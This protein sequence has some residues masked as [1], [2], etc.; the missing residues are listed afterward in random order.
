MSVISS[1]RYFTFFGGGGGVKYI[2]PSLLVV[3][4][5]AA[6]VPLPIPPDSWQKEK[7][8]K[9]YWKQICRHAN[10]W[11]TNCEYAGGFNCIYVVLSLYLK[12]CI[13]V[14]RVQSR[15]KRLVNWSRI[16]LKLEMKTTRRVSQLSFP[17][18]KST[19]SKA[20]AAAAAATG[21]E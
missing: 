17:S 15:F 6:G 2:H 10:S 5:R 1:Y 14:N 16:I 8:N 11:M 7:K 4:I 21:Y 3:R 20:A 9:I 19:F 18:W 13:T 12:I